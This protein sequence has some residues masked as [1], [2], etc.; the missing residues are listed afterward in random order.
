M[1]GSRSR[2]RSLPDQE[3]KEL[4][5]ER[6]TKSAPLIRYTFVEAPEH[7]RGRGAPRRKVQSS[8]PGLTCRVAKAAPQK[9]TTVVAPHEEP[10]TRTTV[11]IMGIPYTV[12][13]AAL[14]EALD[15]HGARAAY[16][17]VYLPIDFRSG[18]FRK[19][20]NKGTNFGYAFVNF[21]EPAKAKHIIEQWGHKNEN[22][23]LKSYQIWGVEHEKGYETNVDWSDKQHY[24]WHVERY[25]NSP[26]MHQSVRDDC[27]PIVLENGVQKPF[28]APTEK[29]KA[30]RRL[31]TERGVVKELQWKETDDGVP[32]LD[33]E[34]CRIIKKG[35]SK[36]AGA[37]D[38]ATSSGEASSA[39]GRNRRVRSSG[40]SSR[41]SPG[42]GQASAGRAPGRSSRGSRGGA[43]SSSASSW[44][45]ATNSVPPNIWQ[46]P[47]K[48]I[49][50]AHMEFLAASMAA[51]DLSWMANV[52]G[53]STDLGYFAR[54]DWGRRRSDLP[55]QAST[56]VDSF[57]D[58]PDF[59][60]PTE[61]QHL[62]PDTDE[63]ML[64]RQPSFT[65]TMSMAPQYMYGNLR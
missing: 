13:R 16:D 42:G 3:V 50:Q 35:D 25:R 44:C 20:Y 34:K 2:A 41:R 24:E 57:V 17:F 60:D 45:E 56:S 15:T 46:D 26:V 32:Q 37:R 19:E 63:P 52:H 54:R 39:G 11:V 29:V 5:T 27:K 30:L 65:A 6:G 8:P 38:K 18:G 48:V 64:V 36:G 61:S 22:C 21:V 31:R 12:T 9:R 23:V 1:R 28:P 53:L 59:E 62:E 43:A 7:S 14:L 4:A 55:G 10:E 33:L 58:Y 51:A 47:D 49:S 40:G